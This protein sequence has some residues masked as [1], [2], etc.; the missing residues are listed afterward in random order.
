MQLSPILQAIR[1]N[2]KLGW[3]IEGNWAP[4]WAYLF[5]AL[6][7][8]AAGVLM[9][10]FIYLVVMGATGEKV[11]LAYL[12]GGAAVFVFVRLVLAAAGWSVI[13]DREH[14][15]TL[16][17]LYIA[18][19]PYAV[20]LIG[21][22]GFKSAIAVFGAA[23]TILAG[24]LLLAIPFR[25]GGILWLEFILGFGVGWV[26]MVSMGW[27]LAAAM[28]LVDRMGW[29]WA[30]GFSGLLFLLTGM[31]IPLSVLPAPLAWV[32]RQL[33][34]TYWAELWRH[35]LYGPATALSLPGMT[36]GEIWLRLII[37][38]LIWMAAAAAGLKL[39]DHFAR[40]W[41]RIETETFY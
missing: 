12:M 20:Q 36:M 6:A 3:S 21:R 23:L 25:P 4:A 24:W 39:A 29:V 7:T 10:V 18:P 35:T 1:A 15:K 17:Y 26:G 9:L 41:G 14:Y 5:I 22:I 31:V 28:L 2:L 11:F 8:P 37:S 32:G 13:E 38:T 16:R 40:R 19:S 27:L 34:V 30:E 33:P